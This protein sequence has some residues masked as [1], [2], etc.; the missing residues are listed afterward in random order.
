[1]TSDGIGARTVR[2]THA[3]LHSTLNEAVRL[4]LISFN[5]ASKSKLPKW[6]RKDITVLTQ[7]Q[8]KEFIRAAKGVLHG[9]ALVFALETGMRPEEYL[10]LRWADL[11][12][13]NRTA[14][15]S[16][17]LKRRK[18]DGSNSTWYFGKPKTKR[19]W[20]TVPLSARLI[21]MLKEHQRAQVETKMLIAASYE[22][23]DLVFAS[24]IGTPLHIE[25]FRNRYFKKTL[26]AIGLKD[27]SLTLYALRH[28]CATLLLIAGINP[29]VVSE[30]LGHASVT[31]T[32]DTYSHVL[33]TMQETA[34][35]ELSTYLYN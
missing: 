32:L 35:E 30:R 23:H 25:N 28:T 31:M 27:N 26:K 6:M 13:D 34:T 20:R 19:S 11:N 24:E 1:M 33:P 29:K 16:R 17:T 14:T 2:L 5:P 7:Q 15:V 12:F 9:A 18:K 4:N 3:V 10:A 8:A 22:K 21:Q